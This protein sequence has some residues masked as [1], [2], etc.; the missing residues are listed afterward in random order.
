MTLWHFPILRARTAAA[1]LA[2]VASFAVG[3]ADAG[4]PAHAA[5][6][7]I[8]E[9]APPA[10]LRRLTPRGET[11]QADSSGRS[12]MPSSGSALAALAVVVLLFFGAARLWK[13]H[14]PKLPTPAPREAIEVLGRCRIESRQ[15]VYLVRLGSRVLVLGSSG[16]ELSALSDITDP[17]E[18]D[19]ITAQCRDGSGGSSPFSRLFEARRKAEAEVDGG[20]GAA[21]RGQRPVR[22]FRS[23]AEQRLAERVRGRA[24]DEEASRVA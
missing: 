9:A 5:P 8:S 7:V 3:A 15:S 2:A 16:G 1:L 11:S 10:A 13:T 17:V 24:I 4:G 23:P 19:L 12:R 6:V 22:W 14:G 20:L 21:A 18:V